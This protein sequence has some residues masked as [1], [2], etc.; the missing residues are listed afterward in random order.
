MTATSCES[1][2][3]RSMRQ[4]KKRRSEACTERQWSLALASNPGSAG[5]H[6]ALKLILRIVAMVFPA[7]RWC[8][9]HQGRLMLIDAWPL[10][11]AEAKDRIARLKDAEVVLVEIVKV[12][13]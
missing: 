6:E 5:N 7:K 10:T 12:D 2:K 3:P 4:A 11:V 1:G 8:I 13:G 9:I